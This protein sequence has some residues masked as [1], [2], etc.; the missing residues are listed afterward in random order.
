MRFS[1][2]TS[3]IPKG[4]DLQMPVHPA[5][6]IPAHHDV[7][8]GYIFPGANALV[9][10]GRENVALERDEILGARCPVKAEAA[11]EPMPRIVC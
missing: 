2:P 4:L 3:L 9:F 11:S 1:G 7:M 10:L 5:V 6:P 8:T